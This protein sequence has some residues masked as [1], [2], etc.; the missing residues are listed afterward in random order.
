MTWS[1]VSFQEIFLKKY[2]FNHLTGW[3]LFIFY[4]ILFV[5]V[6]VG[7]LPTSPIW[8]GYIFPYAINVALFY[9]HAH[10]TLSK[11]YEQSRQKHFLF[12][13]LTIVELLVYLLLMYFIGSVNVTSS[14]ISEIGKEE[15]LSVLRQLWR[16]IYFIGFATAYWLAIGAIKSEKKVQ[17]LEKMQIINQ[18][19][20]H[21]LEKDIFELENAYLKAQ[22]NPHLLFNTL[23]F[24]YNNLQEASPAASEVVILLSEL[25]NYSLLELEADGKVSL[26]KEVT[27]IK[28]IIRINQIRF[29][30][31]LFLDMETN[32]DS[33]AVRVIPLI[34]IPLV[35]NQFKHG[36][37]SNE[38]TPGK[39][40]I[41]Y[42]GEYLE[43][44]TENKV[45]KRNRAS[46]HGI[47]IVNVRKR[48]NNLY[49]ENFTLTAQGNENTFYVFLKIKLN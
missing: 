40:S 36:D 44:Y 11:S 21:S 19:E 22:I 15:I 7:R 6:I 9:F 42:T 30:N 23:N 31:K 32:C 3:T 37:M 12:L 27:Q 18:A 20:K 8:S 5:T 38:N 1:F 17:E 39:I 2:F 25:M 46:N 33:S 48:L 10:F 45:K 16:G 28:N 24:I 4:E 34:L 13:L 41:F 47:G 14:S 35:E 49:K 26:E 43:M 29:N